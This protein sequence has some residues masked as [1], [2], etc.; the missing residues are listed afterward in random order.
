[1]A[2]VAVALVSALVVG[3]LAA[4]GMVEAAAYLVAE[5][6]EF[7][8]AAVAAVKIVVSCSAARLAAGLAVAVS[9]VAGLLVGLVS[10][11]D[12]NS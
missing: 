9:A 6:V 12:M 3:R 2:A 4:A 7:E 11:A 8:T 10:A 5:S 1:M